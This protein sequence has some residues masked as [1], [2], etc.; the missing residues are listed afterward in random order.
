MRFT[1]LGHGVALPEYSSG[2]DEAIWYAEQAIVGIT[3]E[4]KKK[5]NTF[6]RNVGIER[7]YSVLLRSEEGSE[8]PEKR[9][10]FFKVPDW[11]NMHGPP[12]S[13]RMGLYEQEAPPLAIEASRQALE[14]SGIKPDEI[15]HVVTVSCSGFGA[16][17]IDIR[18]IKGLNL[19]NTVERANIGF[20]GCHGAMN[21]LKVASGFSQ[22]QPDAR[23]LLCAVE[24]CSIHFQY[25]YDPGQVLANAL[26]ADGA[27]AMVGLA[28]EEPA[29]GAWQVAATGSCLMPDSEDAMTWNI[30]DHGFTMTLS[31][32]VPGLIN[33]YLRDWLSTWLG[34][35]GFKLEDVKSW[36][37]HP[38]GPA[39]LD[40]VVD[41]LSLPTTA[42]EVS[43]E[44]L[45]DYGNMSSPTVLFII[46]KLREQRAETPC[47][48]LGFGP[49]L[50]AEAALFV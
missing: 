16:P 22:V 13:E 30:R 28:Q 8:D 12:T 38:G 46:K 6:Y 48:A 23:V 27:A 25:G 41:S 5:V 40:A 49:G 7:R 36:A 9:Q 24:L 43:R 31:P 3:E 18:I 4:Q 19:P 26:F 2:V 35:H 29:N 42:V 14:Q 1:I 33:T 21:G 17:G 44:I 10:P 37:I 39:I 50:Y 15:T 11:G 34:L 20:M 47:L 32:A 45:R